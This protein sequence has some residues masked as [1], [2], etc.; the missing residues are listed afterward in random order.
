MSSRTCPQ[1]RGA[2]ALVSIVSTGCFVSDV[3][4]RA[5]L[6]DDGDRVRWARTAR[7]MTLPIRR[8]SSGTRCEGDG[9]GS[10]ERMVDA[11]S[12]YD[13]HCRQQRGL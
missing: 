12:A 9:F 6:D 3:D 8:R 5:K 1:L 4:L 7:P 10:G 2:F 13:Q 11:R